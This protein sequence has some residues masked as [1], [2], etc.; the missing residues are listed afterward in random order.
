MYEALINEVKYKTSRSSGAG[1]QH[2]NKVETKVELIFNVY[3]SQ[4]LTDDE[5]NKI[6]YKL[7]KRISK[8]GVLQLECDESRSQIKNKEIVIERFL[9]LI[10][11]ALKQKKPRDPYDQ[12]VS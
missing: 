10:N 7:K 9:S 6:A 12:Q 11:D 8:D 1:G 5:K 4:V 3:Q 2:V